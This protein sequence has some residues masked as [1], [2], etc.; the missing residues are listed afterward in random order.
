MMKITEYELDNKEINIAIK[1][2]LANNKQ[3]NSDMIASIEFITDSDAKK[4][5]MKVFMSWE[6]V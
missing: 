6:E 3:I 2:Y 4:L 1:E 5:K